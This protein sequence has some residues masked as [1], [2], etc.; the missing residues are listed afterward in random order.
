VTAVRVP[1]YPYGVQARVMN[2][3]EL[4]FWRDPRFQIPAIFVGG[5]IAGILIGAGVAYAGKRRG[6]KPPPGGPGR[7][8]CVTEFGH[9]STPKQV[10]VG[11]DVAL[12]LGDWEGNFVEATWAKVLAIDPHDSNVLLVGLEGEATPVGAER[13]K[14][15]EHGFRLG[16]KIPGVTRDCLAE[17][18]RPLDD[19]KAR[20]L[21][22]GSLLSW[23]TSAKSG[24]FDISPMD[25]DNLP[26]GPAVPPTSTPHE[27]NGMDVQLLLVSKAGVGTA[28]QSRVLARVIGVS[29]TGA[30]AE[31]RVNVVEPHPDADH[32]VK[33]GQTF[34]IT[35]D[36]V[37]AYQN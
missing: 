7:V 19:P 15:D 17:V 35:W 12:W 30:V 9:V 27:L 29:E 34:D 11:S 6:Y 10:Q 36:C 5:S 2:P 21:C 25:P 24:A 23:A 8:L 18:L 3:V 22:G 32:S 1:R 28:W 4:P 37:I 13:L 33:P 16:D 20:L 31:V 14:S 26:E